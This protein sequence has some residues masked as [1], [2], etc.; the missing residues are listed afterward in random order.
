MSLI[1]WTALFWLYTC[2]VVGLFIGSARGR[3]ISGCLWGLALG[4]IGWAVVFLSKDIRET[5]NKCGGLRQPHEA[6]CDKCRRS[7]S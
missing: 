7:K 6:V 2:F 4:P 3:E 5:C 1:F